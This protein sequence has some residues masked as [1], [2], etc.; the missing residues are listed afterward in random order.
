[1]DLFPGREQQKAMKM[2]TFHVGVHICVDEEDANLFLFYY[3]Y[4][5]YLILRTN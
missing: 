5:L 1:M 2:F 3:R 4:I